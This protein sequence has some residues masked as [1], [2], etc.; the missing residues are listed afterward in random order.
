[1]LVLLI[2]WASLLLSRNIVYSKYDSLAGFLLQ[3][4]W[5]RGA[6]LFAFCSIFLVIAYAYL[7][8]LL[9]RGILTLISGFLLGKGQTFCRLLYSFVKYFSL[10]LGIAIGNIPGL[11]NAM[12][13]LQEL[14][15]NIMVPLAIPMMLYGCRFR[16]EEL[17]NSPHS[18]YA[19]Q[20]S[21]QRLI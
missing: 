17:T 19:K 20:S 13:T 8:N 1:M 6:N 15:P 2:T 21:S 5:M 11:P 16:R 3:G 4:D 18:R 14:L 12:T 7:I 9:S 10:A